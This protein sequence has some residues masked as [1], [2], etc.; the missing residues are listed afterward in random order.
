M[1]EN[2]PRLIVLPLERI[3]RKHGL[4]TLIIHGVSTEQA[5]DVYAILSALKE[6][7]GLNIVVMCEPGVRPKR[8]RFTSEKLQILYVSDDGSIMY[9]GRIPSEPALYKNLFRILL[10]GVWQRPDATSLSIW[11][12]MW[13]RT[14]LPLDFDPESATTAGICSALHHAWDY[15]RWMLKALSTLES[16]T[17]LD[18]QRA[19]QRDNMEIYD[20]LCLLFIIGSYKHDIP[21]VPRDHAINL[22]NVVNSIVD[23]R[24]LNNSELWLDRGFLGHA[25]HLL[26]LLAN[27][28][29]VLP[30]ALHVPDVVLL[31]GRPVKSGGFAD[32]FHGQYTNQAGEKVEVAL[33]VLRI[34]SSQANS[35]RR[36]LEEKFTKEALSWSHL[37]HDN[38]VPFIGVNSTFPGQTMA[39]V[40]LWMAQGSVLTYMADRSLSSRSAFSL[41]HDVIQGIS[42]LHAMNIV[43][44][45]LCGRNILIN[46]NGRACLS[47][48]GLAAFIEVQTSIKTSMR[49]GSGKWMAP[50]LL[51]PEVY[52]PNHPF[53]RTVESDVWAFACVICEIWTEGTI[54]FV[55]KSEG[56]IIMK[57]SN[58]ATEQG[59]WQ[60]IP[61]TWPQTKSGQ[62]MPQRLWELV[63]SCWKRNPILRP[64]VQVI[65]QHISAMVPPRIRPTTLVQPLNLRPGT[66]SVQSRIIDH[67]H[68][69]V[70]LG[71][72]PA[73]DGLPGTQF[74]PLLSRLLD[75]LERRDVIVAPLF[76]SRYDA[77]HLDLCF[78][79]AV[80]ANSFAMTWMGRRASPYE[81][82]AAEIL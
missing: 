22:L 54:P 55:D 20:A 60:L 73:D 53:Q 25:Q 81:N 47:D 74:D 50:E 43:H 24:P 13:E 5:P 23:S 3:L 32:I 33:K 59:T 64:T 8:Q 58:P 70:R 62:A 44:G 30:E 19:L 56:A 21:L 46:Q 37:N 40:S 65:S 82:A 45:D 6:L 75:S 17:Y 9:S 66:S 63:Q 38:I 52:R 79:S 28:L 57:W 2:V 69:Y 16:A 61:Y 67:N 12:G 49:S 4:T 51:L 7:L 72:L 68:T 11:E 18:T 15:S 80:E 78:A 14:N 76:V 31:T 35:E 29:G 77:H 34:F 1:L 42:Y 41:I 27:F 36:I 10:E 26:Q 39:M 48:F 71:P